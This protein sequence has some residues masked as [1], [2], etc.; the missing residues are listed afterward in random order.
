M[1]G[2]LGVIVLGVAIF[3]I[4]GGFSNDPKQ[5]SSLTVSV[6]GVNTNEVLVNDKFTVLLTYTPKDAKALD[7]KVKVKS[8]T[9]AIL[10]NVP[11]QIT[12][13]TAYTFNL[14]KDANGNNIGGEIELLFENDNRLVRTNLK[15]MV[16]VPVP[17][18]SLTLTSGDL[19][20][21]PTTNSYKISVSPTA[22]D[23]LVLNCNLAQAINPATGLVFGGFSG[24]LNNIANKQVYVRIVDKNGNVTMQNNGVTAVGKAY[25]ISLTALRASTETTVYVYMHRTYELAKLFEQKWFDDIMALTTG[26]AYADVDEYNAFL[27]TNLKLFNLTEASKEFFTANIKDVEYPQSDGGVKTV[28]EICFDKEDVDGL[29]K[30][31]EYVFVHTSATFVISDI[32]IDLVNS[33]VAIPVSILSTPT[34]TA[35]T[36]TTDWGL[37]LTPVAEENTE[38]NRQTLQN[39]LKD[40][41]IGTY[42]IYGEDGSTEPE[43]VELEYDSNDRL[44]GPRVDGDTRLQYVKVNNVWYEYNTDHAEIT[45]SVNSGVTTWQVETYYPN[46]RMNDFIVGHTSKKIYLI[47]SIENIKNDNSSV[48]IIDKYGVSELQVQYHPYQISFNN[49]DTIKTKQIV[50]THPDTIADARKQDIY[51]NE[52]SEIGLANIDDSSD[53]NKASEYTKTL[54]Y[55]AYDTNIVSVDLPLPILDTFGA[56][57]EYLINVDGTQFTIDGYRQFVCLGDGDIVTLRGLHASVDKALLATNSSSN[58]VKLYAMRMVTDKE[59]NLILRQATIDGMPTFGKVVATCTQ[60]SIAINTTYMLTSNDDLYIYTMQG[61]EYVQYSLTA[62]G[63]ENI[64]QY[65]INDTV[66]FYVSPFILNSTG[67][68][69]RTSDKYFVDYINPDTNELER[70]LRPDFESYIYNLRFGLGNLH[71]NFSSSSTSYIS[72]TANPSNALASLTIQSDNFDFMVNT[73]FTV[74]YLAQTITENSFDIVIKITSNDDGRDLIRERDTVTPVLINVKVNDIEAGE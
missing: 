20:Q 1:L 5:V 29:K 61:S 25:K 17:D 32:Q 18:G 28:A 45:K 70:I 71:L 6:D 44:I 35:A 42:S 57:A 23:S 68:I 53:A 31:L 36:I 66:Q 51:V 41:V 58:S 2:L 7:V 13:G 30:S 22:F 24:E 16:D 4:S 12:A 50:I 52:N 46:Y 72:N 56:D 19:T 38:E 54:W 74:S 64:M 34:T 21:D 26:D 73:S 9:P 8:G 3:A 15:I 49:D 37:S 67:E 11:S 63:I 27:N 14:A 10:S 43:D 60:N 47:Y 65:S 33:A 55:L 69:D 39:R 48:V 59:G 40:V 62:G